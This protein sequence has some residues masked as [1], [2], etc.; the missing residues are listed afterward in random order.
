MKE[1]KISGLTAFLSKGYLSENTKTLLVDKLTHFGLKQEASDYSLIPGGD[2]GYT[3]KGNHIVLSASFLKC[4]QIF[5]LSKAS[6]MEIKQS[7][8]LINVIKGNFPLTILT[9]NELNNESRPYEP[10]G[11]VL[12]EDDLEAKF[13]LTQYIDWLD[14]NRSILRNILTYNLGFEEV[15]SMGLN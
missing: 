12:E 8:V 2:N 5:R 15:D 13:R 1:I 6:Q 9:V 3:M 7:R 10:I 11:R 4:W 14:Y